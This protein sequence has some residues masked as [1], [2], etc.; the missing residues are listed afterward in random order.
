MDSSQKE[1]WPVAGKNSS[2]GVGSFL[3]ELIK[4]VFWAFLIIAPVRMFLF[5]PFFVQGASMEP[6]FENNEY[7]I[8]NEFGYKRTEVGVPGKSFFAVEPFKELI[9][10]DVVVFRYPK[11]RSQFFIK[12]IIG[13]PGEKIEIKNNRVI[14]Y[15]SAN[16]DGLALNEKNYLSESVR[17]S[18]DLILKLNENEYFV[19]GDNRM[20][21]S[22]S[23]YW[24]PVGSADI[25]GKVL[26]RAW[27]LDNLAVF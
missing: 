22:D 13:L 26:L 14:I 7:L 21:S 19:L 27:P 18:G 23:R 11:N 4:I 9:R 8:I 20:F 25:I 3:L 5:Q 1:N 12:R 10:G 15:N 17:T 16:P 2:Y 24:G 6:A